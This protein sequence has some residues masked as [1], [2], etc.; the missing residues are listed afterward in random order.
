MSGLE[1]GKLLF[2]KQAYNEAIKVLTEFLLSNN[3]NAD[4]LYT[5]A[6]CYRRIDEFKK[7]IA[8]LTAIL[9]RLP[10]EA[11]LLSERGVSHFHNKD[12]DAAMDDMNKAVELEPENSY[13]YSSRAYIRAKIDVDGAIEDYQKAVE[14]DPK[15]S[16]ALNNLGLLEENVGKIKSAKNRFKASN[17][18]IGYNPDKR[19]EDKQTV[20]EGKSFIG[21]VMLNVF[22]SS[23]TRK[24]YFK[25]LKSFFKK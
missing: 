21:K 2:E 7:S 18:I 24:E 20:N 4:A 8:D 6:I 10:D 19:N 15:D 12:I 14:L 22:T 23:A 17:K 5:R 11:T 25:F 9:T 16:I 1:K 3:N 13:R